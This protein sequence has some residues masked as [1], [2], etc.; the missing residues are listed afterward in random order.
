[1]PFRSIRTSILPSTCVLLL[2]VACGSGDDGGEMLTTV[3]NDET[4]G[5]PGG[6]G[7]GEPCLPDESCDPG[8]FC[9]DGTCVSS[10]GTCGNEILD[11]GEECDAGDAN[12]NL[13]P[14][15]TESCTLPVCGDGFA[16]P[17]EECDDA[18]DVPGDGCNP[19]CLDSGCGDGFEEM[20]GEFCHEPVEAVKDYAVASRAEAGDVDGDGDLD[21]VMLTDGD[22]TVGGP[23]R[24]RAARA[25]RRGCVRGRG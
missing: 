23:R 18:N 5:G 4:F 6:G 16:Q 24:A 25:E 20:G 12:S 13:G 1:M 9:I 22:I 15:C 3:G 14:T 10:D 19:G 8:L 11:E 2:A 21:L 17:G 7:E